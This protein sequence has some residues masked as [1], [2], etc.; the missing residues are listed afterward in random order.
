MTSKRNKLKKVLGLRE[1]ALE[2]RARALAQSKMQLQDA[3]DEHTRESERLRVAEMQREKLMSGPV[4][5]SSW[6]DAE[7]WIVQKKR[8]V[9]HANGRVTEAETT[10]HQA[11][12]GVVQARIDKKRIELLDSRLAKAETARETRHEQRL[13]DE[14]A[15]RI[16][17]KSDPG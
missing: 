4:R 6:I 16:A 17:R 10:V 5:V 9:G 15:Q 2:Q 3:L 7:Q 14:F 8:A 1:Q 11:W 13:N 12:D